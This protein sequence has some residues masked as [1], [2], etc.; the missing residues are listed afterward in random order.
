MERDGHLEK[1]AC[2]LRR[3]SCEKPLKSRFKFQLKVPGY[4][5]RRSAKKPF[6]QMVLNL[7]IEGAVDSTALL[8]RIDE[9][10]SLCGPAPLRGLFVEQ[11][12]TTNYQLLLLG[13]GVLCRGGLT[14][15]KRISEIATNRKSISLSKECFFFYQTTRAHIPIQ[16]RRFD[17]CELP[18]LGNCHCVAL[19]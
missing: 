13:G 5:K 14:P 2:V 4:S 17:R 7:R 11:Q 9:S 6:Q 10:L 3:S 12:R 16:K 8:Q 19:E 18:D 15:R 1:T